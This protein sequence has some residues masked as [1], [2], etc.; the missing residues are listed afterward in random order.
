MSSNGPEKR[1]VADVAPGMVLISDHWP[2]DVEVLRARETWKDT[3]GR[4]MLRYW[5]KRLDTAQEGYV[6][7]GPSATVSIRNEGP[8][9]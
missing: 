1:P 6:F 7:F 3:F 4:T 8:A 9:R 5:G 2:T